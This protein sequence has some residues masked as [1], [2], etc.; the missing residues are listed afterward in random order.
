MGVFSY[1]AAFTDH[2]ERAAV[3][4]AFPGTPF[5]VRCTAQVL[6]KQVLPKQAA[7]GRCHGRPVCRRRRHPD[8]RWFLHAKKSSDGC[9]QLVQ[10]AKCV[11]VFNK[12]VPR[13]PQ[14]ATWPPSATTCNLLHA[15]Y[16]DNEVGTISMDL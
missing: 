10:G 12:D 16:P 9:F 2:G 14:E 6:P 15:P 11:R 4:S 1:T 13:G 5:Q 3:P 7:P 8:C